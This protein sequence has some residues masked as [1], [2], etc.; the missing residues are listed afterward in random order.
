MPFGSVAL[1][2]IVGRVVPGDGVCFIGTLGE[3][4][5]DGLLVTGEGVMTGGFGVTG[6]TGGV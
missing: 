3:A 5:G 2:S 6:T 1:K 4:D